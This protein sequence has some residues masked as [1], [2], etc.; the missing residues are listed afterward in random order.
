MMNFT[1]R[2]ADTKGD[3]IK[4]SI[5]VQVKAQTLAEAKQK[6]DLL[7]IPYY[8]NGTLISAQEISE[9]DE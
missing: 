1:F 2:L 3:D 9:L 5:I 8:V 4:P 7:M 6:V